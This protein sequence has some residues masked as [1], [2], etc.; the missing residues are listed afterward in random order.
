VKSRLLY[1]WLALVVALAVLSFWYAFAI[2]QNSG[3]A[4]HWCNHAPC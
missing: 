3:D 2:I 1:I 4:I